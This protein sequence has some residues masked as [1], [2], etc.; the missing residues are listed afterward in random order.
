MELWENEILNL[1][2]TGGLPIRWGD[3]PMAIKLLEMI[4]RREGFGTILAD[5]VRRAAQ[6]IGRGAEDYAMH[7]KGMEIP[8]QDGRAQ[9]SMGLAH[10]TSNRGA[11]HLKAFPTVDEVNNPED[12]RVR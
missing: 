2:D 9:K 6:T 3:K 5:G 10:V 8:G 7:V 12:A 1:D 4:V 11:D